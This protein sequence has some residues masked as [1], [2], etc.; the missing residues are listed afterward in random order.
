MA[1][2]NRSDCLG[3][4]PHCCPAALPNSLHTGPPSLPAIPCPS[5]L[6]PCQTPTPLPPTLPTPE[7]RYIDERATR[8]L[9]SLGVAESQDGGATW[10]LTGLISLLDPPRPDSAETIQK[11]RALGV[12]VRTAGGQLKGKGVCVWVGGGV[13]GKTQ[14]LYVR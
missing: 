5:A 11:A 3:K 1:L 8:G 10:E 4:R 7:S 9:R 6:P 14:R 13:G 12:E 2:P